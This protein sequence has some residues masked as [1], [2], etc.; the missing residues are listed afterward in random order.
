MGASPVRSDAPDPSARISQS[1]GDP[2]RS[3]WKAMNL[4]SLE[5][6][7]YSSEPGWSVSCRGFAPSASAAQMSMLPATAVVNR[8]V[9]P[10]GYQRGS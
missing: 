1:V 9:A 5:N 10:S 2:Y 8:I 4:P 6:V 7:G 3:L